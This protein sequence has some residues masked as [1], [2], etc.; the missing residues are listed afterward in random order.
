MKAPTDVH[1]Y[2]GRYPAKVQA[3]LRQMRSAIRKAAPSA[4]ERISYKLPA[5]CVNGK[6]LVW[7]G[8]FTS[9]VGFY[10]GSAAI[11]AFKKELPEYT[12]A[13]GSVQF[14]FSEP[15]P[16]DLVTKIVKFRLERE[17]RGPMRRP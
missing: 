3:L 13:K 9:H 12:C 17:N 8:A 2:I 14:P 15:L 4:T 1:D 10:P 6:V 16:L 7:F 5:F 11:A